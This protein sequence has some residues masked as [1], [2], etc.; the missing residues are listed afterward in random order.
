[1]VLHADMVILKCLTA[2]CNNFPKYK[3]YTLV[4]VIIVD[5]CRCADVEIFIQCP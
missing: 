5:M 4:K 1:M 2:H 3:T